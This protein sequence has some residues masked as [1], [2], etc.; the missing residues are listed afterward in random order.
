M[1]GASPFNESDDVSQALLVAVWLP[2]GAGAGR[3]FDGAFGAALAA[4]WGWARMGPQAWLAR[5][6]AALATLATHHGAAVEGA[7]SRSLEAICEAGKKAGLIILSA[8]LNA[9]GYPGMRSLSVACSYRAEPGANDLAQRAA[10]IFFEGMA[11][12]HGER[13]SEEQGRNVQRGLRDRLAPLRAA[14]IERE[15]LERW[16]VESAAGSGSKR[17]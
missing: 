12:I 14:R 2:A 4:D 3:L 8:Q 13:L 1:D 16:L 5:R 17:I 6:D 15:E 9:G 7:L 10:R 11:A